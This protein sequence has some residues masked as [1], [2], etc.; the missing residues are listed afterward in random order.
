[1]LWDDTYFYIGAE[2][3]EPHLWATLTQHDSVIFHDNDFEVF[4]DPNGDN[5]EYYEFEI[6]ALGTGWDLL[7][8]RP[9]QGRRQAGQQL[10]DSGNE[11][12]RA[13]RRHAERRARH[14][15][16]VVRRAG[17]SVERAR[18]ARA[19]A[20]AAGATAISGA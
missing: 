12:G 5:H 18:R 16:L 11:V 4:I 9:Y 3:V 8:P 10:G 2:L 13:S 1:M 15:S 19:P 7:L 14:R 6:N 17:V 20:V